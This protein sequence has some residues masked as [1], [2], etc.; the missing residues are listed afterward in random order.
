MPPS[1][2]VVV[3]AYRSGATLFACLE[4]LTTQNYPDYEVIVV[5][6]SPQDDCG[7]QVRAR[8]PGVRYHHTTA[9]MLPHAAR[10]LGIELSH[11]DLLVFTDPD[12]YAP[13]SWLA[14]MAAA[15][16]AFG[17]MVAGGLACY[18]ARWTDRAMHLSKF[19][20]WLPGGPT[21]RIDSAATANTA[22]RRDDLQKVGGFRGDVMAGDTELSWRFRAAGLPLTFVPGALVY[23]H[24]L[25]DVT[26]LLAER[27][28]RGR[29]FAGVYAVGRSK[30]QLAVRLAVTL[31]LLRSVK[32][33]GR[34]VYH[35]WQAGQL[36]ASLDVLPVVFLGH[37][38]W[39]WGEAE[40]YFAQLMSPLHYD[41]SPLSHS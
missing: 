39:L 19:D 20:M 33:V 25:G 15:Q 30:M 7:E 6:S 24:H 17:G 31:L 40:T 26:S 13:P 35:T 2:S 16:H 12:I 22:C 3:P 37:C 36:R 1:V 9:R 11:G 14:Q 41:A 23:H 32:L 34:A 38:A 10:N 4:T 28:A 8:F 29:D 5:D 18:G 27:R 21:R